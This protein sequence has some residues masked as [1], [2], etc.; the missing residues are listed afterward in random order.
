MDVAKPDKVS[1]TSQFGAPNG[2][3]YTLFNVSTNLLFTTTFCKGGLFRPPVCSYTG[4]TNLSTHTIVYRKVCCSSWADTNNFLRW[5]SPNISP[6]GPKHPRYTGFCPN[7]NLTVTLG[8]SA[9][10]GPPS[11]VGGKCFPCLRQRPSGG[12]AS[13]TLLRTAVPFWG[14]IACNLTG[15]P[16]KR[17]CG[18][19]RVKCEGV[20]Y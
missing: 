14:P 15:L 13:V 20:T 5:V 7:M 6:T 3:L 18:S 16:P 2:A 10:G 8:L 17:D 9:V 19:K 1:T 11:K 12:V 4:K